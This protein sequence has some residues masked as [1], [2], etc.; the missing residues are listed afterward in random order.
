MA[1]TEDEPG[2]HSFR[3]RFPD[4]PSVG[5]SYKKSGDR[6]RAL[7]EAEERMKTHST[8]WQDYVE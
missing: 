2:I 4:K 8:T 5:F 1:K 6:P 7:G 3:V